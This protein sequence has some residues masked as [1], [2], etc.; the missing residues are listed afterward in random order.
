MHESTI[1][2]TDHRYWVIKTITCLL[3]YILIEVDARKHYHHY[4]SSLL[5]NK[6][7]YLLT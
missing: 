7:N 3:N 5:S 2:I 4:L 1:I 6:N